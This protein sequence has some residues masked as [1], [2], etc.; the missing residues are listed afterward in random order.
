[1]NGIKWNLLLFATIGALSI[2]GI[3]IS[4]GEGSYIGMIACFII[5]IAVVGYGFKTKKKM[6]DEGK[7]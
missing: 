4:L 6:R 5:L 7:L 2:V 1:M 3:G